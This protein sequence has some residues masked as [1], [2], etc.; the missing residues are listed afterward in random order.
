MLHLA[1]I[2]SRIAVEHSKDISEKQNF[3]WHSSLT[4]QEVTF[5]MSS[6]SAIHVFFIRTISETFGK[7]YEKNQLKKIDEGPL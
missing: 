3:I 1:D 7:N 5:K 6:M 2:C 4:S